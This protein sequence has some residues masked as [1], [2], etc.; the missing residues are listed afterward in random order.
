MNASARTTTATYTQGDA[1][2]GPFKVNSL[3]LTANVGLAWDIQ[4]PDTLPPRAG[5][6]AVAAHARRTGSHAVGDLEVVRRPN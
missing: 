3:V 2:H 1:A 4:T 5:I 6:T